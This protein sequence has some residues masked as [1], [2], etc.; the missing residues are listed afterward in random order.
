MLFGK[1]D[2]DPTSPVEFIQVVGEIIASPHRHGVAGTHRTIEDAIVRFP[3]PNESLFDRSRG[4]PSSPSIPV[5]S[6]S[7]DGDTCVAELSS[8]Q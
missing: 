6:P 4:A 8:T 3:V 7:R 2:I 1:Q 5:E